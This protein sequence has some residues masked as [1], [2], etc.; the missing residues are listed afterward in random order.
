SYGWW[1]NGRLYQYSDPDVMKFSGGTANEN[2]SR[3][4][5]GA[6]AGTVFLNG[7]DL[8]S[9]AG[10]NLATLSLTHAS[11]NEVARAGVGFRPVEGNT[12]TDAADI[13]VRQDG[14]TWYVA[15]FNYNAFSVIKS[16]NL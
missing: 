11:I 12:G 5:N 9:A 7:D 4:I 15:V 13:F 8:A 6:I 1:I 3:L 14:S 2:Q 10:Q 16:L